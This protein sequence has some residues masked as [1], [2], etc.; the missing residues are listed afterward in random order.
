MTH[1][2]RRRYEKGSL[3]S[4][5]E[6]EQVPSVVLKCN[7]VKILK[8]KLAIITCARNELKG[9]AYHVAWYTPHHFAV[10]QLVLHVLSQD[11]QLQLCNDLFLLQ[12]SYDTPPKV[13]RRKINKQIRFCRCLFSYRYKVCMTSRE[14]VTF[15]FFPH[16]VIHTCMCIYN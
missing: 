12:T 1:D 8:S 13:G 6:L 4:Y 5:Q 2:H 9:F 7:Q 3:V 11:H 15:L 14:W 10:A 16:Y